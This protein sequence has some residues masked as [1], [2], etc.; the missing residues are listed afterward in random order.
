MSAGVTTVSVHSGD[1][2]PRTADSA[3][4]DRYAP[5]FQLYESCT[6]MY[7]AHDRPIG[8]ELLYFMS[9]YAL[10]AGDRITL[11]PRETAADTP[12]S[13][14]DVPQNCG[15]A[16]AGSAAFAMSCQPTTDLPVAATRGSTLFTNVT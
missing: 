15:D 11:L 7:P 16:E 10:F 6:S 14:V 8:V 3:T 5:G 9:R 13:D 2:T 4:P 1:S 12:A